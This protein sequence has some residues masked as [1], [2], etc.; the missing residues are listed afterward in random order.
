MIIKSFINIAKF[1]VD[2]PNV[3]I[4]DVVKSTLVV[5]LFFGSINLACHKI[6]PTFNEWATPNLKKVNECGY[7]LKN[8]EP[9]QVTIAFPNT[10][11]VLIRMLLTAFLPMLACL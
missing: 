9:K 4:I 10:A 11:P 8:V 6:A 1:G 3:T 5:S 2:D 7:V